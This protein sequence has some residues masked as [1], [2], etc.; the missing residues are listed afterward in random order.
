MSY[1]P[2]IILDRQD[3]EVARLSSDFEDEYWKLRGEVEDNPKKKKISDKK[4]FRY[5]AVKK[6]YEL[7][8]DPYPQIKFKNVYFTIV[9]V[10]GTQSNKAFRALLDEL[11]IPY[12]TTY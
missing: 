7:Q 3:I 1:D 5:E 12:A 8:H 4:K 2:N 11:E 10:E 9:D 6:L